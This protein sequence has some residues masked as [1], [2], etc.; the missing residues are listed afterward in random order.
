MGKIIFKN[1]VGL[2]AALLVLTLAGCHYSRQH[3]TKV[4]NTPYCFSKYF[5]PDT[6]IIKHDGYYSFHDSTWA[7]SGYPARLIL[8]DFRE[9]YI[10]YEDGLF[11]TFINDDL[12]HAFWGSYHIVG[13]TIKS[14][15]FSPPINIAW[16][17]GEI[18]FKKN[19]N[20]T[21]QKIGLAWERP[22]SAADIRRFK[23]A[24]KDSHGNLGTFIRSNNL[25]P[26]DKSW[27]LKRKWFWCNK[28]EY[29]KWKKVHNTNN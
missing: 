15:F 8:S 27:L 10:F 16:G 7:T 2:T 3:A 28:E 24:N 20:N 29:V 23:L 5:K 25:P 13:D 17:K 14:Q 6:D 12:K 19:D 26:P 11:L 4:R 9:N 18:W 21:L 1:F 22:M